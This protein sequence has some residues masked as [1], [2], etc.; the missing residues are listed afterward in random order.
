MKGKPH[1]RYEFGNKIGLLMGSKRMVITA[2][3]VFEGN[4]HDSK[5]IAP[6]LEQCKQLHSYEPSEVLYDRGGRGVSKVG[7]TIITIPGKPKKEDS[8][9]RRYSKRKK[10]RRRAAIEALF[11]HL[12][13][14]H[15]MA[16]NY[17]KTFISAN[18]NALLACTAWNL[19]KYVAHI[20]E[21]AQAR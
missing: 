1:A 20:L 2:V 7:A 16:V 19:M 21:V 6:L 14:D 12:K 3:I 13:F 8:Y 10:F 9:Y 17:F 5:T 15:R 4:P 11:S 18:L